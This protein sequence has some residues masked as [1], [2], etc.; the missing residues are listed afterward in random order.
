MINW[1]MISNWDSSSI[2]K[3]GLSLYRHWTT[4][5]YK[6][7]VGTYLLVLAD[8]NSEIKSAFLSMFSKCI[9]KSIKT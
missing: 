4:M 6:Y 3:N 7:S 1:P 5:G 2:S 9:P 8:E